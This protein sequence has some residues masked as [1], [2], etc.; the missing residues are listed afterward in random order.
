MEWIIVN[1]KITFVLLGW[2][3]ATY[4]FGL[5]FFVLLVKFYNV[6]VTPSIH[7]NIDS[8]LPKQTYAHYYKNLPFALAIP[9]VG[10]L[11]VIFISVLVG[12]IHIFMPINAFVSFTGIA[13]GVCFLLFFA[14]QG[15]FKDMCNKAYIF[16][17][18]IAFLFAVWVGCL[19]ENAY[20]TGLYHIQAT[21]WVQ[22]S[23]L[24]F[25]I[26]NIHTRFGFNN[27]LYNFSAISEVSHIV[28]IR[29]FITNEIL[30]FFTL[31]ASLVMCLSLRFDSIYKC[32]IALGCVW[33]LAVFPNLKGL[34]AEGYLGLMGFCIVGYL[35]YILE[36]HKQD[37]IFDFLLIFILAFF[38]VYI[39][40]SA[41]MLIPCVLV[42]FFQYFKLS[43]HSFKILILLL[44]I[45]LFLGVI[46][47][48]KGICLSG[49]VAYPAGLFYFDFLP[50][51]VDNITRAGEVATIHNWAKV[52]EAPNPQELLENGKWVGYWLSHF[53]IRSPYIIGILLSIVGICVGIALALTQ[54]R[55]ILKPYIPL[56][57][58]LFLG[59]LFWF[60]SAPDPRFGWQYFVPFF[61]LLLAMGLYHL[62]HKLILKSQNILFACVFLGVSGIYALGLNDTLAKRLKIIN[63]FKDTSKI[64]D[65]PLQ[66]Y[67]N[68][69]S[70]SLFIPFE[71]ED[72]VYDAPLPASTS[73]RPNLAKGT[74]L[75]RDMYYI[76]APKQEQK[77]P[78]SDSLSKDK[79]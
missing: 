34:Y 79:Q 42:L 62:S 74:F 50:W 4:G 15:V 11:G 55:T 44:I 41:A 77:E 71:G 51:A 73:P 60:F 33:L 69:N 17:C 63:G 12:W 64:P 10:L 53:V 57:V 28:G 72:R 30:I 24:V 58:C 9:I 1:L 32:F 27:I 43:K 26:A 25:G 21:K 18:I 48:I 8:V 3:L 13:L 23:P 68:T 40:I 2:I 38:S 75:G 36:S 37:S 66:E 54:K 16:A 5:A 7:T 46:W 52:G 20:D 76:Q 47:G 39:K 67:T 49:A 19:S 22:E 35:I 31:M 29:S 59:I 65:S 14:I 70:L 78:D 56:F 61:G 45:P 6:F